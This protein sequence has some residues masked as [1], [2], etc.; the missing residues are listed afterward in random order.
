[1]FTTDTVIPVWKSANWYTPPVFVWPLV[2]S[3]P[4][5]SPTTTSAKAVGTP[6]V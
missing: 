5:A 2:T 6:V 4:S 3:E 1:M